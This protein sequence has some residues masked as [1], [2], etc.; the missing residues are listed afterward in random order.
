MA[1]LM[2][3]IN[4]V[5]NT[6]KKN[7]VLYPPK[8]TYFWIDPSNPKNF[9][10]TGGIVNK[11]FNIADPYFQRNPYTDFQASGLHSIV[12]NGKTYIKSTE[13]WSDLCMYY[14]I[15]N[16]HIYPENFEIQMVI[17]ISSENVANLSKIGNDIYELPSIIGDLYQYLFLAIDSNNKIKLFVYDNSLQDTLVQEFT[18][19]N[20]DEFVI[21]SLTRVSN[22]FLVKVNGQT[23]I[24]LNVPFFEPLDSAISIFQV[25]WGY[26]CICKLGELIMLKNPEDSLACEGYLAHKWGLTDKL[27]NTHIYKINNPE[28]FIYK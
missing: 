1:G 27:D 26:P 21:L 16:N 3:E 28:Y 19:N 24:N 14:P 8:N 6:N 13:N 4:T 20:F 2:T 9:E 5:H 18:F 7:K 17:N 23:K 15:E 12:E 11:I 10:I 25:G 22:S